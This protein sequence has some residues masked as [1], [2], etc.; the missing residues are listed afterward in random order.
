MFAISWPY[1][2]L[3]FV[4]TSGQWDLC[5]VLSLCVTGFADPPSGCCCPRPHFLVLLFCS[6]FPAF[7]S[8]L[9]TAPWRSLKNFSSEGSPSSRDSGVCPS[10]SRLTTPCTS[11][12]LYSLWS[13]RDHMH[14][15][16]PTIQT[17]TP[18]GADWCQEIVMR[19]MIK[20]LYWFLIAMQK[21]SYGW[22]WLGNT[23][24]MKG[25]WFLAPGKEGKRDRD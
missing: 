3:F 6:H 12:P 11:V 14:E 25:H 21:S 22:H 17:L 7:T 19:S 2:L 4:S 9:S 20:T 10:L 23:R 15:T 5:K 1:F 18:Q 16:D 8:Q 24:K 13:R